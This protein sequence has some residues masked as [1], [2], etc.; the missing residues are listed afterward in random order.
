MLMAH[1]YRQKLFYSFAVAMMSVALIIMVAGYTMSKKST[2]QKMEQSAL[3]EI[4]LKKEMFTRMMEHSRLAF[5][6]LQRPRIIELLSGSSALSA[7]NTDLFY[8]SAA[9]FGDNLRQ[10]HYVDFKHEQ[11]VHI[12]QNK[13]H[14]RIDIE[15]S[16]EDYDAHLRA[17]DILLVYDFSNRAFTWRFVN[18]HQNPF[19]HIATPL[20]DTHG[21]LLG[22]ISLDLD[23]K[24]TFKTLLHSELFESALLDQNNR[25]IDGTLLAHEP[26]LK[27]LATPNESNAMTTQILWDKGYVYARDTLLNQSGAHIDIVLRSKNNLFEI[28]QGLMG[29]FAGILVLIFFLSLLLSWFISRLHVR[30]LDKIIMREELLLQES[31][32]VEIG[33]MVSYLAHQWKQ[34]LNRIASHIACAKSEVA[35]PNSFRPSLLLNDLDTAERTLEEMAEHIETFRSF[36]RFSKEKEYFNVEKELRHTVMM[37]AYALHMAQVQCEIIVEPKDIE[38]YGLKNEWKH[39]IVSLLNNAIEAFSASSPPKNATI[40]IRVVK[41]EQDVKVHISDNAGG[42]DETMQ[43]QLFSKYASSKIKQGGSGI[44]LYFA[45]MIIEERFEGHINVS[46]TSK[47]TCFTLLFPTSQAL[48]RIFL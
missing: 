6:L 26:L 4:A 28:T 2:V 47:G 30:L 40:H 35:H 1:H 32:L 21:A 9:H 25:S 15:V 20:W 12:H 10:M 48:T 16:S 39:A 46:S 7:T 19:L 13:V 41:H 27:Q 22:V 18:A 34:P 44:G 5:E 24:N 33:G 45:K 17:L 14:H 31:K 23:M 38:L 36:Y 42:I 11:V 3:G 29:I 37:L 8:L 43:T